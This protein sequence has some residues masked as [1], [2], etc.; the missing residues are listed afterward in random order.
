MDVLLCFEMQKHFGKLF[1]NRKEVRK[2]L[3]I[4]GNK[5]YR[6]VLGRINSEA[7]KN[8]KCGACASCT[9]GGGGKACKCTGVARLKPASN[10]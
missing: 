7:S 2:M 1:Y 10:P 9:G 3:L 6:E 4:P 5:N 8:L